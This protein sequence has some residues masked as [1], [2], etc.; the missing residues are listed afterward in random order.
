MPTPEAVMAA[1]VTVAVPKPEI[2]IPDLTWISGNIQQILLQ[3]IERFYVITV[4][5]GKTTHNA[6][7]GDPYTG[8]T[9]HITADNPMYSLIE[10]AFFNKE[11][12]N[13]GVR[14]FGYDKQ[15]GIEKIIIDR[16]CVYHL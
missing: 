5:D 4:N 2:K 16:V 10:R 13:L 6:R 14:D 1:P 3:D 7:F 11:S 9:E 12:V 15:A 8:K